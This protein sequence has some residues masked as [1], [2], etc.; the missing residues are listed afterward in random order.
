MKKALLIFSLCVL[1]IVF[2]F[3][4][5]NE[6]KKMILEE[7][8]SVVIPPRR[9]TTPAVASIPTSSALEAEL[10]DALDDLV[11][12]DDLQ[13]LS[14]SEVH[15]TPD[16]ILEAGSSLGELQEKAQKAPSRRQATLEF[17][18]S[19]AQSEDIATT[20]RAVCWNKVITLIPAWDIFIPVSELKVPQE[21]QLLASKLD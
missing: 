16:L 14:A 3:Q 20:I 12:M 15:E 6:Q 13:G 7:Q 21:I 8:A 2:F 10:D 9:I 11:T 17:F 18:S 4:D 5:E 19:C 1:T